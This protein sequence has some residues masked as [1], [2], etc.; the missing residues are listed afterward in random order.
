MR[1]AG[2]LK[3]GFYPLSIPEAKRLR[4]YLSFP[5]SH[6]SAIDPCV[7]DGAAFHHLLEGVAAQR[8]G[9]ELDGS[10]AFEAHSLGID[11]LHADA[12]EVRCRAESLSLL[13][14]NP[15]YDFEVG[16]SG[17]NKRMELVFLR[18]TGRWLKSQGVLLFI[19]PQPRLR[20]C[21]RGLAELFIDFRVYRLKEPESL[22]FNQ[23][24]VLA[25]RRARD[26]RPADK[27][28]VECA[29]QLEGLSSQRDLAALSDIAD[30]QYKVPVSEPVILKHDGIPL[31]A[32]EDQLLKSPAYRQVAL[33]LLHACED[34][35]GRPVT[36]LH[37]G[38]VGLLCTAGLLDG[39]F[40]Q[41]EERHIAR[42][43]SRKYVDHWEEEGDEGETIIH[44]CERFTQELTLLYQ[45]GRTETLT[46]EKKKTS[47]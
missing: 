12:L 14:L 2:R 18:H 16:P 17:G 39:V 42:W 31:D 24:A 34:A 43:R 32:V 19:I 4:G 36:P 47:C 41:D 46:H 15:P 37:G 25:R 30:T 26:E 13:Y 44:D 40:G 33:A 27:A 38:H 21:A 10:R 28:L 22:R 23:I 9:I 6:F 8:Y 29:R 20:E 3:L 45:D 7:G 1:N 5:D 35:A 11:V